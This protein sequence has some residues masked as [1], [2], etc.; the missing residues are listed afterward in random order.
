M[1]SSAM[2]RDPGALGTCDTNFNPQSLGASATATGAAIDRR[3]D[4]GDLIHASACLHAGSASGSPTGV[5]STLTLE[6]SADGSTGW[7]ALADV[8]GST[9]GVSI[10]AEDSQSAVGRWDIRSAD[11]YIRFSVTNDLTGGGSPELVVGVSG[12]LFSG[13]L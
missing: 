10:S 4:I 9:D 12:F 7:T 13:N 1:A 8:D 3:Q 2:L 11:R 6:H 5:A